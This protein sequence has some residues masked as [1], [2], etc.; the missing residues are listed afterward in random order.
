[1]AAPRQFFDAEMRALLSGASTTR[2]IA[3]QVAAIE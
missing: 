2:E 3:A 1:V